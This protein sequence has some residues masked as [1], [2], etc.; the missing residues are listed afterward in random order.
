MLSG[1]E[2]T[3]RTEPCWGK[4]SVYSRAIRLPAGK[5]RGNRAPCGRTLLSGFAPQYRGDS[6]EFA[7]SALR[8][9]SFSSGG[10]EE[11]H[12]HR[13]LHLAKDQARSR[14][15]SV[16]ANN[17]GVPG[18]RSALPVWRFAVARWPWIVRA[19]E[20]RSSRTQAAPGFLFQHATFFQKPQKK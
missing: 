18:G 20:G 4:A 9:G 2:R 16:M 15:H 6:A 17:E 14:R 8:A 13:A 11:A 3:R 10:E 5:R 19:I 12:E 7:R 1:P